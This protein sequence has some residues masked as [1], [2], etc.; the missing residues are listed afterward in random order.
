MDLK[1]I[2]WNA[3]GCGHNNFIHFTRQY[4]RDNLPDIFVFVETRV[5]GS[6]A[7]NVIRLLSFPNSCRVEAVGFSGGIWLCWSDHIS[8]EGPDFTWYKGPC[9]VRLDRA[10][11]N[12]IWFEYFPH[13]SVTHL[14]RMKSDHRPLLLS[15]S[16][17]GSS[18]R[19]PSFKYMASW[20]QHP[21]FSRLLHDSWSQSQDVFSNI[22]AFTAAAKQWNLEVYGVLNSKKRNLLARLKGVQHLLDRH[23]AP[24]LVKLEFRLQRELEAVLDQEETYWKQKSRADWITFGDRNTKYFHNLAMSN[25]R[26]MSISMLKDSTGEWCDDATILCDC[27]VEFFK[28][29]FACDNL[30]ASNFAI[31]GSDNAL[32]THFVLNNGGWNWRAIREHVDVVVWPFI[33]AICPPSLALGNDS[34]FGMMAISVNS[35]LRGFIWLAFQDRL[36]SN[37][38]RARRSLTSDS[39]CSLCGAE[40]ESLLHILRDC[41]DI[42]TLWMSLSVHSAHRR[43]FTMSLRE[44][45]LHGTSSASFCA[46]IDGP[47]Q[48]LFAS[49]IWQ[50]WKR[51]NAF[52]LVGRNMGAE[53]LL[54]ISVHWAKL[55]H[56]PRHHTI[57]PYSSFAANVKWSPPPN[58]WLCLNSDAS[59]SHSSG[60]GSVGG[61]VRDH[62]GAFL[63]SYSKSI[64]T[65]TVLQAELWGILEGLRIARD[66]GCVRIQVQSDSADAINLLSPPSMLSPFSLVRSIA[67]FCAGDC[68]IV[69]ST[70]PREANMV[71][72]FMSKLDSSSSI[73]IYDSVSPTPGLR[74]LLHRDSFGPPY[75]RISHL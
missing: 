10:L 46:L 43:F 74:D 31:R 38:V 11:C 52:A 58:G 3:Q 70:I 18:H 2:V 49:F 27:G 25:S 50:A 19:T 51:R 28:Q 13:A 9:Y 1:A 55:Y 71:A 39:S 67:I 57:V 61:V 24:N 48:F 30:V 12:D 6:T 65:T 7:D 36:L 34:C 17:V 47:F 59:L 37:Q 62:S 23:R 73:A 5:S 64:G 15:L 69:F 8:I 29:L 53:S 22:L 40:E 56:L 75:V 33:R 16:G 14:L 21:D 20:L 66:R 45:I 41:P 72:D 54:H 44:W 63:F 68:D 26:R 32:L 42:R 35:Q 4:I 60:V